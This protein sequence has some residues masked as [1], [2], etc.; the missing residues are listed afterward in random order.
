MSSDTAHTQETVITQGGVA[1]S[2]RAGNS[3]WGWEPR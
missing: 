1:T 3:R 2:T